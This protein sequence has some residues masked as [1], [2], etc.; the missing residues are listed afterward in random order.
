MP[1]LSVSNQI[2]S[3]LNQIN[4]QVKNALDKV[5]EE[6]QAHGKIGSENKKMLDTLTN[7]IKD[8]SAQVL[9]LEQS[10]TSERDIDNVVESIGAQFTG[11]DAYNSFKKG[12]TTKAS[13][14]VENNIQT[15]SDATVA[16][17]RRT[18]II[19]SAL[20]PLRVTDVMASGTT[21]S[22]SI[23][24]TRETVSANAASEKEEGDVAYDESDFGF[25][26][27][28]VPVR[29]VGT[30]IP[31]SKQM[32]EDA[33]LVAS[34]INGRLAYFVE[35]RK[36]RQALVGNG[37]G[38]SLN[39]IF[40]AGNFTPLAG[41]TSGDDQYKN[42]RRAQAQVLLAHYAA[43]AI[44]LNPAD[45][46]NMDLIKGDDDQYISTNPR[47]QSVQTVW[48]LPVVETSAMPQG[49]FLLGAFN[50]ASQFTSRAGTVIEMTDSHND[51][52]TK[53]MVVVKAT[54]RCAVEIYRPASLV[55]GALV[56]A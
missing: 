15:G 48:G 1:E 13:F 23:E 11:S 16:P 21:T 39:G 37:A 7:E 51:N 43:N 6:V 41:A 30:H 10:G 33:P 17:D 12:D 8:I 19:G 24:Y 49:Q 52:F 26:L 18:G 29:N 46:A 2:E 34:Y 38:Q 25:E 47:A 40:N 45:M 35:F 55:G 9:E 54:A 44:M 4:D 22:N 20:A 53:D 42:I 5:N 56:T 32:I 14:E 27:V 28:T 36:D 50:L 3:G 31:I